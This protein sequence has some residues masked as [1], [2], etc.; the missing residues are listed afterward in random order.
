MEKI[1]LRSLLSLIIFVGD[2]LHEM[3]SKQKSIKAIYCK[4]MTTLIDPRINKI[5]LFHNIEVEPMT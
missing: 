5:E 2:N 3:L 4:L 1:L